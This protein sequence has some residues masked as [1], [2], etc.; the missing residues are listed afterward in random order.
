MKIE[1]SHNHEK[2]PLD[3][4]DNEKFKIQEKELQDKIKSLVA[5]YPSQQ[6]KSETIKISKDDIGSRQEK[7]KQIKTQ[8]EIQ[9]IDGK[10]REIQIKEMPQLY[11][12]VA[13]YAS[14]NILKEHFPREKPLSC[15][16]ATALNVLEAIGLRE[17]LSEK[18]ILSSIKESGERNI[19]VEKT[20]EY[21]QQSGAEMRQLDSVVDLLQL[22]REGGVAV[23]NIEPFSPAAHSILISGFEI[24]NGNITFL[25]NDPAY[26]RNDTKKLQAEEWSLKNLLEKINI[27][28]PTILCLS[29]YGFKKPPDLDIKF[30]PKKETAVPEAPPPTIEELLGQIDGLVKGKELEKAQEL[31]D[32]AVKQ[33]RTLLEAG[34]PEK[35]VALGP[36]IKEALKAI[37]E[38]LANN[39]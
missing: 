22:L 29:L 27:F 38:A 7:E 30:Y 16:A 25:I 8:E 28:D 36:R 33:L 17:R 4:F 10:L 15:T 39:L 23:I 32:A 12:S 13:K 18:D 9:R 14:P 2:T 19:H 11:K 37:T 1:T 35:I 34:E 5:Q 3:V 21:L 24:N 20:R 6:P 31:A 26:R